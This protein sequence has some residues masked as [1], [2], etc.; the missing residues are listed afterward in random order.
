MKWYSVDTFLPGIGAGYVIAR[1]LNA[2]DCQFIYQA[3]YSRGKWEFWDEEF[4][5]EDR[6]K[7][8]GFRVTHWTYMPEF[9]DGGF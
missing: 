7:Q 1:C 8:D 9:H 5:P 2:D 4:W 6:V 3:I